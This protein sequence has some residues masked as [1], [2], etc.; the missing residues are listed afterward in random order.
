MTDVSQRAAEVLFV[1]TGNAGRSQIAAA[2]F[3]RAAP[4]GVA[5]TSAGVDPWEHVHPMAAR[6]LAERDIDISRR[7]PRHVRDVAREAFDIVV[8]IGDR[9]RDETPDMPGLPL[10]I[11]WDIGDPADA[12]GTPDS[13]AVFRRTLDAIEE[14]LPELVMLLEG[15][16]ARG[17][18]ILPCARG[19]E[20]NRDD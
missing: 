17:K 12:D 10:R 20:T 14:R 11:H 13:E 1:C 3:H 2:L 18:A 7:R 5:V 9:A 4:D 19:S 16:G 6:I 15:F 8:T